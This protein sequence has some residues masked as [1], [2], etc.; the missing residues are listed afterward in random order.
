MLKLS[1]DYVRFGHAKS[2]SLPWLLMKNEIRLIFSVGTHLKA[3]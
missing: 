1:S 3:I 2:V